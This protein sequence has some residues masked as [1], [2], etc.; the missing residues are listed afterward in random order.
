VQLTPH[1]SLRPLLG[2]TAA[3]LLALACGSRSEPGK[4]EDEAA[5]EC[6]TVDDCPS[7]A[8]G[9]ATC[10]EGS[11]EVTPLDCDDGDPC[12]EDACDPSRGCVHR[13]LSVDLDGD[14]HF[15]PRPG[16]APGDSNACGGDC[17]DS[18]ASAHPDARE[19]CD[20]RDNDC[21]GVVDDGARYVPSGG[22][23]VRISAPDAERAGHGGLVGLN[24]GFVLTVR[25]RYPEDPVKWRTLLR[26]LARDGSLRFESRI[27]KPNV[28]VDFGP[29]TWSGEDLVTVWEDDRESGSY[30]IYFARF[31]PEGEKLGAD[32]RITN[33]DHFSL[34]PTV[35]FNRSEYALVWDDRRD[36]GAG[37]GSRLYGQRVARDGSLLGSN[38][39]ITRDEAGTEFPSLGAGARRIGVAYTAFGTPPTLRFRTLD[40]D[41]ESVAQS[42]PFAENG[43]A[44]SVDWLGDGFAVVWEE[45]GEGRPGNALYGAVF[46]EEAGLLIK[47]TVLA[48]GASYL[49][50]HSALSF[51]DRL[52]LIWADDSTGNYDLHWQFFG[53][54]LSALGL[55]S[56]LTNGAAD[57]LSPSLALAADGTVGVAFDDFRDGSRQVYFTTLTCE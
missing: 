35:L 1:Y 36:E 8:C 17:D 39:L 16:F 49:R 14:G 50:S 26:G 11:C 44:P 54:D 38:V 43:D 41:L 23:A 40:A 57:S 32:L 19:V 52:L 21:N 48:R 9:R 45:V 28:P 25:E 37:E 56:A 51:G 20:G 4:Y 30:E 33:S 46:D 15:S 47:P 27:S 7:D 2:S 55:R 42:G 31:S 12:T 3:L 10:E 13:A 24:D 6:L 22:E 34:N 18:A 29:L 53:R 5:S